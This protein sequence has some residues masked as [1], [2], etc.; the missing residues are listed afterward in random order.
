MIFVGYIPAASPLTMSGHN[1][2][3][4]PQLALAPAT[5]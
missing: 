2:V 3:G 1:D 5:P 4:S